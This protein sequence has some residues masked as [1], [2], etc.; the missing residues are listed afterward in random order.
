MKNY[1]E[2]RER[3][4][5]IPEISILNEATLGNIALTYAA[6]GQKVD[7]GND[8]IDIG[9]RYG[10]FFPETVKILSDEVQDWHATYAQKLA[11]RAMAR[12]G[13]DGIDIL[14]VASTTSREYIAELTA[15]KLAYKS[16][17]P[18]GHHLCYCQACDGGVGAVMD[19]IRNPNIKNTKLRIIVVAVDSISGNLVDPEE[20][21]TQRMF[22]NGG[23]TIAFTPDEFTHITGQTTIIEDNDKV[24]TSP[25][26]HKMPS[27]NERLPLPPGYVF[28][29]GSDQ[30]I[31]AKT[32]HS[33]L[34][35]IPESLDGYFHMDGPLTALFFKT[36]NPNRVLNTNKNYNQN[37]RSQYGKLGYP[38]T[39]QPSSKVMEKQE[40]EY[41]RL[42]LIENGIETIKARKISR[43]NHEERVAVTK[44]LD[45]QQLLINFP[46][47]MTNT[48][49]NNISA[50]CA[51]VELTE[52]TAKGLIKPG[53]VIPVIG[54]G[55]GAIF[56][57][58]IIKIN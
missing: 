38:W 30:T 52:M 14:V 2:T 47:V 18:V 28:L 22:G 51:I 4:H 13:W 50:G 11:K 55:I 5:N 26:A 3:I 8:G 36:Y 57:T 19:M 42:V 12:R 9:F 21:T 34:L 24:I 16:Y 33:S 23:A 6:W 39:H 10:Y 44:E 35:Y 31:Y 1:F 7:L 15:Q 32:H 20:P 48:G 56:D 58:H 54:M 45:H 46:W 41:I 17:I 27:M 53:D 29:N 37:Y 43:L 49:V 40:E 25:R